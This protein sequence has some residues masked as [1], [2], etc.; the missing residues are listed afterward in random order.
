MSEPTTDQEWDVLTRLAR[1][2]RLKPGDLAPA[3]KLQSRGLVVLETD[4]SGAILC[5][6]P[7]EAGQGLARLRRAMLA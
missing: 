4:L 1:G 3:I 6:V 7:T 2:E 5:A